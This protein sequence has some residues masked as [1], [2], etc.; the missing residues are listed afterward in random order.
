MADDDVDAEE[1]PMPPEARDEPKFKAIFEAVAASK[2]RGFK[3]VP[4]RQTQG[5][6][7]LR[8]A[9]VSSTR[10]AASSMR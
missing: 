6:S 9:T 2:G 5:P 8:S 1:V 4:T 7:R 3:L 10:T